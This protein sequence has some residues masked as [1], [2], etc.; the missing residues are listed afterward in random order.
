MT[1]EPRLASHIQ[2]SAF[3][4]RAQQQG[5]F[6]TILHKGDET[7]GAILIIGLVRGSKPLIYERFP[8]LDGPPVWQKILTPQTENDQYV[9]DYIQKRKSRDPDLWVIELDTA[10]DERLIGLIASGG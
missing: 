1:L 4:R 3:L 9:T 2:V 10:D 5:D 6:A 7:S 8:S